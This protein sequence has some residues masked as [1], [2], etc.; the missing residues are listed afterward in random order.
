MITAQSGSARIASIPLCAKKPYDLSRILVDTMRE[1][2]CRFRRAGKLMNRAR[3][4]LVRLAKK[5]GVSLRQSYARVDEFALIKQQRH[6]H[7]HQ[8]QAR[9]QG[10]AQAQDSRH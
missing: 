6:A 1:K 8:V 7:A 3:E 9:R 5:L 4:K 10:A 2:A